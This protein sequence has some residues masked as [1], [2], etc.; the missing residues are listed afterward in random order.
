MRK[1]NDSRAAI[2]IA[3]A[4][5]L[6]ACGPTLQQE[7]DH[8]RAIAVKH[9]DCRE[10]DLNPKI[11]D[12]ET[13][14]RQWSVTCN[15]RTVRIACENDQCSEEVKRPKLLCDTPMSQF[16]NGG[17]G[18]QLMGASSTPAASVDAVPR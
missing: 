10:S 5:A 7:S 3:L 14:V 18:V 1:I 12:P 8:V 9:L 13:K 16:L 4:C 11:D 2:T 17:A 6:G 15:H